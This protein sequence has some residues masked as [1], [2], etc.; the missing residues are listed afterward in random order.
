MTSPGISE[1]L[2]MPIR[3]VRDILGELSECGLVSSGASEGGDEDTYQ[4]ARDI[5]DFS[6]SFII[7]TLEKK[8]TDS[9]PVARTDSL[10]AL[11]ETLKEF[12]TAIEKSPANS[13]LKDI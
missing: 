3:L 13:L 7:D 10:A 1:A 6:I 8:G 12:S 5:N 9:I 11:S 2:D 4:P